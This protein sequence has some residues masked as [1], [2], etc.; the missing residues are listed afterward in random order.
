MISRW[1][2]AAAII[3]TQL[4]ADEAP[5]PSEQIFLSYGCPSCHGFYG[6]GTSTGPRLQGVKEDILL[7]RLLNL[8]KGKY[9][10][11]NGTV[12]ISFAQSLDAN[13]TKAMA[14]FLSNMKTSTDDRVYIDYS[15]HADGDS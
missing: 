11:S 3:A 14:H 4:A 8:Q 6:Q 9:R 5:N 12:M 2:I 13:Q 1:I 15:S 10:T 7:R